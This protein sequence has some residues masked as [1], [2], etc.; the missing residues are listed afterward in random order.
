[1]GSIMQAETARAWRGIHGETLTSPYVGAHVIDQD[2]GA[3]GQVVQVLGPRSAVVRLG[4]GTLVR[5]GPA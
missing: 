4:D 1:M 3:R 2:S 5:V